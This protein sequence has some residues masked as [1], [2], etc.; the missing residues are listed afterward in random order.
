MGSTAR[1]SARSMQAALLGVS[2]VVGLSC[3]GL[4]VTG[5]CGSRADRL[6]KQSDRFSPERL[7]SSRFDLV[8]R[9]C[10][11]LEALKRT[12]NG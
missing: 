4:H 5:H 10:H 2:E 7:V 8:G 3:A 9:Y 1:C 6:S 12:N 11:N